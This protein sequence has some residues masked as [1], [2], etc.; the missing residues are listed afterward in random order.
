MLPIDFE[1]WDVA[2]DS[3]V[4]T[5]IG[6]ARNIRPKALWLP[7]SLSGSFLFFFLQEHLDKVLWF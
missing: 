3:W 6:I 2:M 5:L 7:R 4:S 1:T